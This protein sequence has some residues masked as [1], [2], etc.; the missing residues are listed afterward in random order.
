MTVYFAVWEI[1][2]LYTDRL[3]IVK[4]NDR[5]AETGGIKTGKNQ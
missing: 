2:A 3:S 4:Q 1:V 5:K